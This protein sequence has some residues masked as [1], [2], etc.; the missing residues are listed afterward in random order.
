[1]EEKPAK[2]KERRKEPTKKK[3]KQLEDVFQDVQ[4]QIPLLLIQFSDKI[5]LRFILKIAEVTSDF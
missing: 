3:V 1:M 4:A 5:I 2:K